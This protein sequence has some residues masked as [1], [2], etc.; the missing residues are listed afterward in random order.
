MVEVGENRGQIEWWS[1]VRSE[2]G[3]ADNF[4]LPEG[5][6]PALF[7]GSVAEIERGSP[8]GV[9]ALPLLLTANYPVSAPD[10]LAGEIVVEGVCFLSGEVEIEVKEVR[11]VLPHQ[12]FGRRVVYV[13]NGGR[14][15]SRHSYVA[16]RDPLHYHLPQELNL[17]FQRDLHVFRPHPHAAPPPEPHHQLQIYITFTSPHISQQLQRHPDLAVWGQWLRVGVGQRV[18]D[19]SGEDVG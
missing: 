19:R 2:G 9:G 15:T 17:R 16:D 1:K 4:Y 8:L 7:L 6:L 12:G 18:E 3:G 10:H 14:L 11:L 13:E 5:K